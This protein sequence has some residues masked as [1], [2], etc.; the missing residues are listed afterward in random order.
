LLADRLATRS[1]RADLLTKMFAPPGARR[2]PPGR[3]DS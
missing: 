3:P 2:G 1:F